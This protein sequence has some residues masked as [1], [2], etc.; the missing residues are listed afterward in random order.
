[1][2]VAPATSTGKR[3][4][5]GVARVFIDETRREAARRPPLG[6]DLEE[7]MANTAIGKTGR[8]L[9]LATAVA[10]GVAF[11][12]TP[13]PALAIDAGAAVGIGLGALA[14][15]GI[16]GAASNPYYAYGYPYGY[17]PPAAYAYPYQPRPYSYA[18]GYPYFSYYRGW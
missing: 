6:S 12:A 9:A 17:Y 3:S 7:A 14:L 15:G 2:P 16:L 5:P 8:R 1:L 13:K 11:T 4:F 18:Y 10:A